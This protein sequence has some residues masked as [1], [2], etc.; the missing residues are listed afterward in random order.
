M[1]L[2]L[3]YLRTCLHSGRVYW[4]I[5]NGD[6]VRQQG[7]SRALIDWEVALM[8]PHHHHQDLP[9]QQILKLVQGHTGLHSFERSLLTVHVEA[10]IFTCRHCK[11]FEA[12]LYP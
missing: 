4:A 1:I 10:R 6:E 5:G 12:I 7:F 2:D 3:S 9:V 11:S 8:L